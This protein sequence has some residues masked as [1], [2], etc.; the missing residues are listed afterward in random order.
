MLN[1]LNYDRLWQ[2]LQTTSIVTVRLLLIMAMLIAIFPWLYEIKTRV[3]IDLIPDNHA[4]I[5]LEKY[6]HGIVKCEWL[7]PYYCAHKHSSEKS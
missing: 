4:G 7:Y 2:I 1:K 3:G 6:S 5:I